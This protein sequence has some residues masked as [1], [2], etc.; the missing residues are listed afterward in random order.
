MYS[1]MYPVEVVP[2]P[3][4]P[5][6]S[7]IHAEFCVC[8]D[9][10]TVGRALTSPGDS[11]GYKR[12]LRSGYTSK[13]DGGSGHGAMRRLVA[14]GLPASR[15]GPEAAASCVQIARPCE[16]PGSGTTEPTQIC[17]GAGSIRR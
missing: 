2:A 13:A 3:T 11:G 6:K 10:S 14:G 7:L 15:V 9:L 16:R 17:A 5:A 8:V 12:G 4:R 1:G